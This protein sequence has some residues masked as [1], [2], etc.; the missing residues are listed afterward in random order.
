[1]PRTFLAQEAKWFPPGTL[2]EV[3][4]I[5]SA[6]DSHPILSWSLTPGDAVAFHMLALHATR[7]VQDAQRRR[8]FSVRLLGDDMVHAPRPWKTSPDFPGLD[9]ELPDG[10]PLSHPLFP[11]VFQEVRD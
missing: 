1:M 2:A 5:E 7:G 8:V 10:S 11:L 3:P 4:D 6:R 9:G